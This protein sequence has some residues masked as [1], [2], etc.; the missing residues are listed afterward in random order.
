M[1]TD[2]E[3]FDWVQEKFWEPENEMQAKTVVRAIYERGLMHG[4]AHMSAIAK[5]WQDCYHIAV[6][7]VAELQEEVFMLQEEV[8]QYKFALSGS[9]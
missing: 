9:L 6:D 4:Q 1:D 7:S 8:K 2:K 3:L 5:E